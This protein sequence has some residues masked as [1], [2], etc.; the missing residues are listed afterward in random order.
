MNLQ[1]FEYV[2]AVSHTGS[3]THA[4]REANIT[5]SA[6]SQSINALEKELGVLVFHRSKNGCIPTREGHIIIQYAKEITKTVGK[7]KTELALSADTISGMI[8]LSTIPTSM[9]LLIQIASRFK[10]KYPEVSLQIDENSSKEIIAG[11]QDDTLDLG[12]IILYDDLLPELKEM[13]I[14]ELQVS[15]MVAVIP[16]GTRYANVEKIKPEELM[17]YQLVLYRDDFIMWYL[18]AVLGSYGSP[19]LM[20]SSNNTNAITNA[21]SEGAAT[22][23]VDYSFF[24][25]AKKNTHQFSYIPIDIPKGE[26]KIVMIYKKGMIE[27]PALK[28]FKEQLKGHFPIGEYS[29]L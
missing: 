22:F 8:H 7:M 10:Q 11:I 2:L 4:S 24:E 27:I 5:L 6:I 17:S 28:T 21:L 16:K 15:Q 23:G 19:K 12:I 20:F 26:A 1:Q 13:V 25:S 3:L 18:E 29:G 14:E 9:H